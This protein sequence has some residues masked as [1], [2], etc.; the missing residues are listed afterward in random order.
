MAFDSSANFYYTG[1]SQTWRKLVGM[2]S[3]YFIVKGGGGGGSLASGG[4]GSYVFSNYI[5]LNPSIEY[6]VTINVGSGGNPPPIFTG[7]ESVGG[8]TDSNGN[9]LINTTG[10]NGSILVDLQSAGGGGM[11][12]VF[13]FDE[14]GNQFIKII[15]GGGG[16]AG[17]N[18]LANGGNSSLIG[19]SGGGAGSGEGGNTLGNGNSGEGGV[20]GGANG[21]EYVDSSYNDSTGKHYIFVGGGGGN[22]GTFAGGGGGA[23]YGGGAGGRQGGGGGGGS[24]AMPGQITRIISGGG[25]AGGSANQMGENGSVQIYY[26]KQIVIPPPFVEMYMLN[27]QHTSKSIY[28]GPTVLSNNIINYSTSTTFPNS[29]VIGILKNVYVVGSDGILYAFNNNLSFRWGYSLPTIK[30]IGT[31]VIISD[32]TLYVAATTTS[33]PNY[34]YAIQDI[35]TG[36]TTGQSLLK[37][38]YPLD[39]NSSLSPV[40]DLSGIIYI[41]T[42]NG[43]IYAI[44]DQI[45]RGRQMWKYPS[46]PSGLPITGA[47]TFDISYNKLCYASQSNIYVLD[48]S[49]NIFGAPSQNWMKTTV[50]ANEIY[51]TPSIDNNGIIYVG[52]SKSNAS[53]SKVYTY[54]ISNN[55]NSVWA[56]PLQIND[57][58]LS[59]IAIG[60]KQIYFTSQNAFNLVN[61]DT[62]NLEWKYPIISTTNVPNSAPIIDPN[63]NVYFGGSD[64]KLHSLNAPSRVYKWTYT[65]GGAV[66]GIPVISNNTDIYFGSGDGKFYSITGNGILPS[67][68]P[69]MPM[70]MLNPQHTGVNTFYQGP[71]LKPVIMWSANFISNNLFVLPSIAINSSGTLYIGSNNGKV[72]ALN[73]N[74]GNTITGWPVDLTN[75][76]ASKYNV[77]NSAPN[78]IYTTP[79]IAPDGTIYVGSNVGY[80]HALQ[81]NGT[82]KWSYYASYPLQSSP[83]MD[84]SGSIYFGAGTHVYAIGDAG[85]CG[86][87]KWLVPFSAG[88]IINSSP[89]LGQNGFLY[90]GSNDGYLYAVDSF[91][92][93]Y[94]WSCNL[95]LPDTLV[96][97]PIYTSPTVDAYNNVIIGNGSSMDGSLNYIDG[98][99][100]TPIW[101]KSYAPLNGP[102]YNTAAV[103]GDVIYLSTIAYVYAIDRSTGNLNWR[104]KKDS[105]YYTSPLVDKNGIIYFASIDAFTSHGIVHSVIDN[106]MSY[107]EK[108]NMDTGAV[109][110]L[111]PPVLGRNETIYLSST[112]NKIYALQ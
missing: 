37:W 80:L 58:N 98:I 20:N 30:F 76:I 25:G 18:T 90:F 5:S 85:Y 12:S 11:S 106:G 39:G 79:V 4:G 69:V 75:V 27:S 19:V 70:Y 88:G 102:F 71:S 33:L 44:E 60:S 72:Y 92:G 82:L 51:G 65:T 81:P 48:I 43:S 22:G 47:P 24:Y 55:G 28:Y 8:Q 101:Q 105:C 87:L 83:I 74:T 14:I 63:S 93:V 96:V 66:Q 7:G 35:G 64:N 103:K 109:E 6:D 84:S 107:Q 56:A 9:Y 10:G 62:G 95:N 110:R 54:D 46:M 53:E 86:Y 104:F 100:G 67:T 59:T 50:S 73:G 17:N 77:Q 52:T 91:T 32:G 3:V 57:T 36:G 31:P 49:T 68:A 2:S 38:K 26:N 1:T 97:H 78:A 21:Y 45:T 111:A 89:A 34:L 61:R 108:W 112:R 23:G 16:G 94:K 29:A 40:I 13:Y 15:A 42:D 41:T 99:T